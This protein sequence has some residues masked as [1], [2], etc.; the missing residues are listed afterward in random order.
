[1]KKL[2]NWFKNWKYKQEFITIPILLFIFYLCNYIFILLFP[3]NAFFDFA[4]QIETIINNIIMFIIAITAANLSLQIIFPK[5]YK[6]LR[7]DF[8]NF[9]FIEHKNTYAVAILICFIIAAAL[10]F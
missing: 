2:I 6:F 5:I 1:M 4:S 3:N 8:Y 9:E 10:I 7:E